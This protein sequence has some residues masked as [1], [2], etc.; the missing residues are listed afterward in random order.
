[1]VERLEKG[2]LVIQLDLDFNDQKNGI[3]RVATLRF[4]VVS[5]KTLCSQVLPG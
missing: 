4:Q 3:D 2:Q 1:M 5:K